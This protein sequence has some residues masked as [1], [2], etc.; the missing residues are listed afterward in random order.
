MFPILSSI[1]VGQGSKLSTR[2]AF[3][4]S[5]SYISGMSVTYALAGLIMGY[6]GASA[7]IQLYM[8]TPWI[9]VLFALIFVALSFSMFGFYELTLPRFIQDKLQTINNKKP[10]SQ[11]LSVMIMG[12][13]SALVVSPCVSAPLA[14]ILAYISTTG[15]AALGGFALLALA[16]GMGVPLLIIGTGGGR[17]LPRSGIWMNNIKYFFGVALLAVAIWLLSRIVTPQIALLMWSTL[18]FITGVYLNAFEQGTRGWSRLG[19][20]LGLLLCIYAAM[21]SVAAFTGQTDPLQRLKQNFA[22]TGAATPKHNSFSTRITSK[23]ELDKILLAAKTDQQTVIIDIYADWCISCKIIE[24]E[25]A[26]PHVVDLLQGFKFVKFDISANTREQIEFLEEHEL[27]G[28][29]AVLFFNR[30]EYLKKLQLV[31][32]FGK[33][34]FIR[35]LIEVKDTELSLALLKMR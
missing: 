30:G 21:L 28:P 2:N 23:S 26:H 9:L 17:L 16:F 24:K 19:K 5:L 33:E 20:A 35:K 3:L 7:N 32:E 22:V 14:G 29:P 15:N 1:I 13:I 6:F 11:F 25:L 4:L 31:G 18:L 34:E 12:A 10:N 8:Q 27:F